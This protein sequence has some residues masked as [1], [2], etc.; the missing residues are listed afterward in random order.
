[1]SQS[2]FDIADICYWET[3]TSLRSAC[4][5]PGSTT[6]N[7]IIQ[8]WKA[9][10][11]RGIVWHWLLK[12]GKECDIFVRSSKASYIALVPMKMKFQFPDLNIVSRI[13]K[14]IVLKLITAILNCILGDVISHPR[15]RKTIEVSSIQVPCDFST[16][17]AWFRNILLFCKEIML[18][19]VLFN[20]SGHI[21]IGNHWRTDMVETD[22]MWN[23]LLP[24]CC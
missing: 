15:F 9:V 4:K 17:I 12:I 24:E 21:D 11:S 18:A 7:E 20:T 5:F 16:F 6:E 3:C 2:I 8:I 14:Q 10:R 19:D 23:H 1:M 22:Q 13:N